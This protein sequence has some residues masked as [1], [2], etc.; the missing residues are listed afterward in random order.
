MNCNESLELIQQLLNHKNLSTIEQSIFVKTWEGLSYR[1]IAAEYQYDEGYIREVGATLWRS[2]SE[3]IG[4]KISKKNLRLHL[5]RLAQEQASVVTTTPQ[6]QQ[7][8]NSL[9]FPGASLPFGSPLYVRRSPIEELALSEMQQ[10]GS[11]IRIKAAQDMGKTSL[12][13]HLIGTAQ[14][15]NM[16]TVLVDVR[17]AELDALNSLDRFLRWFCWNVGQQLQKTPEFDTYWFEA[18][19][20]SLSCTTY[21]QEVFLKNLQQPVVIVIDKVHHLIDHDVLLRSF[22]PL[23]RSWYEQARINPHWQKLRLVLTHSTELDLPLQP[24]Q[25]PFNVGLPLSLPPLSPEQALEL[26]QCYGLAT[27]SLGSTQSLKSL[28]QL[29][30]GHPYLLQLAFYHLRDGVLSLDDLLQSAATPQS[31]YHNYLMSLWHKLR[32][33]DS[34]FEAFREVFSAD[35]PITLDLNVA[36]RLEGMGLVKIQGCQVS[37][38]CELYRQH[39]GVYLGI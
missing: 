2:L 19:G 4:Y 25:S 13:N 8:R 30:D 26:A 5:N 31:I 22:F 1:E 16:H 11:L 18:A 12:I 7:E 3:Q 23:L 33:D 15:W 21:I 38:S 32:Q 6:L 27:I 37:P 20:S 34:L 36:H 17:Q 10:P 39:F 35:V 24:H 29:V 9:S 14:H 28:I